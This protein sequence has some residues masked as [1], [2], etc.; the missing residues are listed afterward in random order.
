L[1][2]VQLPTSELGLPSSFIDGRT[3]IKSSVAS[4]KALSPKTKVLTI[5]EPQIKQ[6]PGGEAVTPIPSSKG[7]LTPE[8]FTS[9][10]RL[11]EDNKVESVDL[12]PLG[13]QDSVSGYIYRAKLSYH[14]QTRDAP[15]SVV[16]KL[17]HPRNLRTPWLL[18]AYA[19]EVMFYRNIAPTVGIPV[20]RHIHSEIDAETGDYVLAIEDFPNSTNVRDEAGASPEQAYKL[21]EYMARLHA[22]NWQDPEM[23]SK[24][25]GFENS[26]NLLYAG[27]ARTPVFLSRFSQYLQREELEVFQAM[28]GGFKD[29]VQ[30][31]LESPKTIVHNDYAMKNILMVERDGEP[32]FVLVDWANLRWGPGARDLSFFIMT[33]VPPNLRPSGEWAF[34]RHYWER[35]RCEGVSDYSFEQLMGDY[36]RC[37]IMDMARMV[38]FGGGDYFSPMYESIT[39]HLIRGRTGS[40]R[41]LNLTSLFKH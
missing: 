8:W 33:S 15:E 39:R 10:L 29:V 17:P 5:N 41:E 35:L 27:L 14:H 4:Y 40:A 16:L 25:L 9:I 13:E 22:K 18:E 38:N 32:M 36:R 12:Q 31:L 30:S 20:P 2:L 19:N 11:A 7:D 24:I 3:L 37:I 34:L 1:V 28:P 21:I 23:G 6:N 26:V